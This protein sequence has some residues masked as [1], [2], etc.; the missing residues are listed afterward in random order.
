MARLT[1]HEVTS[2]R[3]NQLNYTHK[4]THIQLLSEGGIPKIH[5]VNLTS[6]VMILEGGAFGRYLGHEG[7][8]L[9]NGDYCSYKENSQRSLAPF[10][11]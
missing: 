8:A 10:I 9:K 7:G 1:V 4:Y 6:S 2:E 11:M 5:V 3:R